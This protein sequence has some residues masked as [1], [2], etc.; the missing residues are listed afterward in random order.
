MKNSESRLLKNMRKTKIVC[1]LGPATDNE[2]IMRQMMLSGMNVARLNFSHGTHE[3][4]KG[5]ADMVKK[6][7]AK[8]NLPIALMLDTKGPEI[9][10]GE[11]DHPV[12]LKKGSKYTVT[13][14]TVPGTSSICSVSFKRLPKEVIPG[15]RILIDDGLI[16]LNVD[17]TTDTDIHCTVMNGGEVSSHKS[18]NVP[19]IHLSLPFIS[20]KD[21]S[22]IAFAVHE[23]FDFI[24]A[25]FT[26]TAQDILDL[27]GELEKLDCH[28]IKIIAKIESAGGVKNID[29]IIRVSDG[30]MVARGD[31]G[32]EVPLEEI[33]IIQKKLIKK[34]SAAGRQ[35][36]TATQMLDSMIKNPRPTRAETT[37]VANAIYDGTSAI[38]LSGETAAGAYPVQAVQTMAKIAE[39]TERDIDYVQRFSQNKDIDTLSDV[40]SAISH[41]TCTTA[42]DLGAAAILTVTKSGR[43]ARMISRYRPNCPIISGTTD[44]TVLRQMNLSWGVIPIMVEEKDNTDELFDH[45]VNVAKNNGLVKDGEL[46]V[47]TAGVPLG[48][49][50]TTNLLKVQLVGDVLVSGTG[51]T[52]GNV[53][54]NVCVCKSSEEVKNN[55]SEGDVLVVPETTNGLLPYLRQASAIIAERPGMNSHAAIV[56]LALDKAVI[57]GANNATKILK[58]GTTV[59]VDSTRGI[60]YSGN[61]KCPG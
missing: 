29:D 22:D 13:S 15:T 12:T 32:V 49:S 31:L 7:R 3:Q 11:F 48:M 44:P 57:V 23:D 51:V 54:G 14:R 30:V 5:Y 55:L 28:K 1:T 45:V 60:V 59:T 42:H 33:P 26:R 52:K 39:R 40:T 46:V 18:I 25:S 53:C 34:V 16:E 20:D 41:A 9:R 37:D 8:L 35:V 10:T 58:S 56:G 2:D 38:M 24:A 27:R 47:I 19:G 17:S 4:Q 61:E 21:R 50:G 6:L 36:I 43:T